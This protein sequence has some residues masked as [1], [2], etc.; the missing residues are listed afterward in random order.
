M[1]GLLDEESV[2]RWLSPASAANKNKDSMWYMH[3]N[4]SIYYSKNYIMY[5]NAFY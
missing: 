5:K 3:S 2:T 4:N 1:Q